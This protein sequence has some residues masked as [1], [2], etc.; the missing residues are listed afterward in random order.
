MNPKNV[1]ALMVGID[2]YQSPVPALEG[3]VND[4]RAFADFVELRTN[5][6]GIPLHMNILENQDATRMKIVEQFEQHL[7]QAGSEDMIVFYYSGHGSQENAH[8]VFWSLEEDRKNETLVCYDSRQADGMDLAD[9]ELATL[10]DLVTAKGAQ[11]AVVMD[12]C[13]SGSATRA[14]AVEETPAKTRVRQSPSYDGDRTLDSYILPRDQ[15]GSR[16]IFSFGN[17]PNA[18]KL[19]VPTPRHVAMSATQPFELA[20]ETW[21]GGSPRG[22]FTYSLMEVLGNAVGPQSYLDV[23]RQ[24]RSLVRQRTTNQSPQLY[25]QHADDINLEFLG[26]TTAQN[27]NYY[28]LNHHMTRGWEIDA[29]ASQGI[30]AQ[31]ASATELAVYDSAASD[32]DLLD[33]DKALGDISV[34]EVKPSYS[35][36]RLEGTLELDKGSSYRTRI[37]EMAVEQLMVHVRGNDA[38]GVDAAR[39]AAVAT[40]EPDLYIDLTDNPSEADYHVVASNNQY[41]VIRAT[42]AED[43]PLI[44][45]IRGYDDSQSAKLS[46][47]LVHIAKWEQILKMNN[48][49]SR[50]AGS[51]IRI[52]L[53]E[54]NSDTVIQP[55]P[56]GQVFE[57]APNTPMEQLPQVRVRLTNTSG[58]KLYVSL[59]YLGSQFQVEPSLLASGGVWLEP[60]AEAY[61]LN[62]RAFRMSV[63]QDHLALGRVELTETLKVMFGTEELNT[64]PLKQADLKAPRSASRSASGESTRSL[65]FDTNMKGANAPAWNTNLLTIT[66]KAI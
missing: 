63:N 44:E 42:D 24:V 33:P 27:L 5:R 64:A 15:V 3:C 47:N 51:S 14:I 21:L 11:M 26:G 29:G 16:G 55:E 2:K 46:E 65:L 57:I 6:K 45:Q 36:V 34:K 31:N 20:K 28:F 32:D 40:G 61:A 60:G 18:S 7:K 10:I 30:P 22:V 4:M 13:N 54:V 66:V 19:I 56:T 25:A 8:S 49:G 58:E 17:E 41:V 53:V 59:M 37:T 43:Q 12:C 9:K 48:P 50:L 39:K 62:G 23:V 38:K 1:F 52:D 35:T